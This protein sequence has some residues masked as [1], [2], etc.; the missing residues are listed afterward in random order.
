MS[1]LSLQTLLAKN[2]NTVIDR[3]V[4]DQFLLINLAT[5]DYYSLDSVGSLIWQ[6]IDGQH[7][8]EDLVD[9]VWQEYEADRTQVVD[10]VL[11]LA[12]QLTDEGLLVFV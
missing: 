9:S 11:R 12:E 6:H 7:T 5:G 10:D 4:E 3:L 8:V 2:T 1:R